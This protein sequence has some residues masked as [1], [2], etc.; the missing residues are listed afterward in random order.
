[1]IV[2]IEGKIE[3]KEPTRVHINTN[4]LIYEVFISINCSSALIS[5]S[6]KLF[7]TQIIKEDSSNLY[8]FLDKNEKKLF[9]TVIKINGVGPKVA[10]AICSTFTPDSFAQIVLNNDVNMLKRVPGIGPKGASRILVELSG[11]VVDASDGTNL[12]SSASDAILALESLG[13]KKDQINKALQHCTSID[14]AGLVKEALKKLQ[15]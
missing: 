1:V 11:F 8:G 6:T 10:L 12:N 3:L 9:D 4:G 13:F 2:G 5:D 15:K 14:T 7:I